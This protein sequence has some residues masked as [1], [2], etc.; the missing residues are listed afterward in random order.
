MRINKTFYVILISIALLTVGVFFTR[1]EYFTDV[2][3]FRGCTD[4]KGCPVKSLCMNGHCISTVPNVD[5]RS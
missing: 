2:P 5:R 4:S 3:T 1:R